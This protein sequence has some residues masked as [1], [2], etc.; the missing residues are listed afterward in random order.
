M[1]RRCMNVYE[2][3]NCNFTL[4]DQTTTILMASQ[5]TVSLSYTHCGVWGRG[6]NVQHMREDT[7]VSLE[8]TARYRPDNPSPPGSGLEASSVCLRAN[9]TKAN[10][11]A[12][13][14]TNPTLLTYLW[15]HN[16]LAPTRTTFWW[17]SLGRLGG[18]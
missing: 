13:K 1:K 4:N 11:N 3:F 7:I 2:D 16:N 14:S 12:R 15:S 6:N 17:G 18:E 5:S 9:A 8:T 10:A